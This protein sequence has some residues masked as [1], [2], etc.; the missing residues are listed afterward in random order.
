MWRMVIYLLIARTIVAATR[1][2]TYSFIPDIAVALNTSSRTIQNILAAQ[3]ATGFISPLSGP[4]AQRY[5]RKR[6]MVLS[7][8]AMT[9]AALVVM[10][11]PEVWV[12]GAAMLALGT[13]K[14]IFEPSMQAYLADRIPYHQR[15][16]AL[17]VIEISWSASLVVGAGFAAFALSQDSISLLFGLFAITLAFALFLVWRYL[18][19]DKPAGDAAMSPVTPNEI[20]RALRRH[21]HAYWAMA[22]GFLLTL[23]HEM[24]LV[25]YA[26]WLRDD[27]ALTVAALGAVT[28]VL[29]AGELIGEILVAV[30]ADNIGIK[31]LIIITSAL[32][33][34]GYALLPL[35]PVGLYGS[36]V[37]L[38]FT[39]I[40]IEIAI[41]ASFVILT[42]V[43][44]TARSIMMT[45]NIATM[46]GGRFIGAAMGGA[47]YAS[48]GFGVVGVVGL[49]IGL[50]A[51]YAMWRLHLPTA[52]NA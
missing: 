30:F 14:I 29:F 48:G 4:A 42:E 19:D 37:L 18:P 52:D 21:P 5:G 11:I 8:L 49:V 25:N 40:A 24:L 17:G 36:I 26:L 2:F 28:L 34:V 9:M 16:K 20:V 47:L 38:F 12:F 50:L 23:P 43:M 1:R 35:V 22:Y 15:G 32:A 41:V 13:A 44:P 7:L 39:T 33:A 10:A 3:A 6:M 31:T 51:S 46:N 45:T 27:Y